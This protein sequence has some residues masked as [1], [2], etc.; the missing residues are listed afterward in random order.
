MVCQE[1][2]LPG[3]RRGLERVVWMKPQEADSQTRELLEARL[4]D[5][6]SEHHEHVRLTTSV[7]TEGKP[8][9]ALPALEMGAQGRVDALVR[10]HVETTGRKTEEVRVPRSRLKE[11]IPILRN[12]VARGERTLDLV[13]EQ[14]LTSDQHLPLT[15][16]SLQR[17]LLLCHGQDRREQHSEDP[18]ATL[19]QPTQP[20]TCKHV[21]PS[22]ETNRGSPFA[23][24]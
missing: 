8:L 7:V 14:G 19:Q 6:L 3:V 15:H 18:G 23:A 13:Q 20:F 4:R 11:L 9:R 17:H 24:A 2:D 16:L 21:S 5:A 1:L 12:R 22:H 10:G